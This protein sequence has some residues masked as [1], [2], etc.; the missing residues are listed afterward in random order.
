MKVFASLVLASCL[1]VCLGQ[2]IPEVATREGFSTLV[3]FVVQ[4][5]LADT[6]SGPGPF[7]V[8]APTN[9]AFAKLPPS[10]VQAV[11]NDVNLLRRVLTYH[12]VPGKVMSTD[13]SN[14]L[15]AP[16]VEGTDLRFNI[17]GGGRTVTVNGKK[18]IATDVEASN[19]IIHVVD[20]VIF[21][22][23]ETTVAG[24][25][26]GDSRFSTLLTAVSTA[27]LVD[28]LSG[29]GPFTVFAP[30]NEAF[31][32]I[33]PATLQGLLADKDALTKTLL[34]HVVPQTLFSKGL[35]TGTV[36]TAGGER[37]HLVGR[38][39]HVKRSAMGN[40]PSARVVEKDIIA[41]NGVIHAID[42]VL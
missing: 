1:S 3:D 22:F 21:P 10:V 9:E 26:A 16:S 24:V 34:R 4:A 15:T 40:K 33:D 29:E 17:Y 2:T 11:S 20:E 18:I 30:T 7:T 5:G 31:A 37:I 23:P 36:T 41:T 8:F 19:G 13:L 25:V 32:K 14:E 28:T 38:M 12:V 35:M 6:L 39:R 27:G 42:M